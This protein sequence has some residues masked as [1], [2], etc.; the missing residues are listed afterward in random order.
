MKVKFVTKLG[1]M[2]RYNDGEEKFHIIIP[3]EHVSEVRNCKGKQ[4]R[5]IMDDEF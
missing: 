1:L 3:K 4:V 5:I 2:G